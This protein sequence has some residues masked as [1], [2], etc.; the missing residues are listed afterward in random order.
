MSAALGGGLPCEDTL[1]VRV[2]ECGR[3]GTPL[4]SLSQSKVD[5]AP[6]VCTTKLDT[7]LLNEAV[8]ACVYVCVYHTILPPHPEP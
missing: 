1:N 2:D 3:K 8:C 7:G 4:H 6:S 5:L